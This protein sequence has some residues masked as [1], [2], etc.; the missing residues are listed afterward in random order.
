M[1]KDAAQDATMQSL[2]DLKR[3]VCDEV[4]KAAFAQ[5]AQE[6][7]NLLEARR[8]ADEYGT[9][10]SQIDSGN[11][12]FALMKCLEHIDAQPETYTVA[13]SNGY[14]AAKAESPEQAYESAYAAGY[15]NGINEGYGAGKAYAAAQPA[16][17]TWVGLTEDEI[18]VVSNKVASEYQYGDTFAR[19]I[20]TKLKEK[21]T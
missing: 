4:G 17:R 15:S 19:A 12:Y 10:D 21:N 9:P 6:P 2:K 1:D 7:V 14:N 13:W 5:P 20:E 18:Q 3:S 11:L 16:Q 8:I